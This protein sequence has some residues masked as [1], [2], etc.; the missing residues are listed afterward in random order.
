MPTTKLRLPNAAWHPV[1]YRAEAGLFD[2]VPLG[3][4][5]HTQ[6]GNGPLDEF[7]NG[8]KSPNRKFSHAW[9]GKDGKSQQ[10][11]E[12]DLRSWAQVDGNGLYWSFE[13]EGFLNEPLTKPQIETLALWHHFLGV[14]DTLANKSGEPGIGIHSMVVNTQ[15]PGKLR[16]QQRTVIIKTQK[17]LTRPPVTYPH[18]PLGVYVPAFPYSPLH[19][20]GVVDPD[21]YCHSGTYS[22]TDRKW[23]RIFQQK[24]YDRG[25][26]NLS[27][28][29]VY[30][31]KTE[32]T[33]EAFQKEKHLVVSGRVGTQ[34]W[35]AI[36]EKPL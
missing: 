3:W 24:M 17:P 4:I 11:A 13:T 22:A 14:P 20:F 30:G 36:W 16:A 25:W 21:Q 19:Y 9:V 18:T 6:N 8:L 1:S 26:K 12:L 28:D 27:V 10:Y 7:F 32:T 35:R 15:C 2:H 29:G 34:T 5:L 33:I 23:I 31:L